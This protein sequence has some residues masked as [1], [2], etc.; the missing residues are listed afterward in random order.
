M[1]TS[2][3]NA[4]RTIN[5]TL[6]KMKDIMGIL[7]GTVS[8]VAKDYQKIDDELPPVRA[9]VEGNVTAFEQKVAS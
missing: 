2:V 6:T 1:L 7:E 3:S 5:L 9:V 8:I 4:D